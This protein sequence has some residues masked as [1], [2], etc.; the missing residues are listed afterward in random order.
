MAKVDIWALGCTLYELATGLPPNARI[1]HEHLS[2]VVREQLPKLEGTKYSPGL[3]ELVEFCF[4]RSPRKRPS[5]EMVQ[6]H[7]YISE[8]SRHY[9]TS[10][11]TR[12]LYD[13]YMWEHSGGQRASLF[14]PGGAPPPEAL[15][16][17]EQ[18][19]NF[20]TTEI[21]DQ[22]VASTQLGFQPSGLGS[23]SVRD[24]QYDQRRGPASQTLEA[25]PRIPLNPLERLF[26]P[27]DSYN[28]AERGQRVNFMAPSDLP[29]REQNENTSRRETLIDVGS[30]DPSTGMAT[31]PDLSTIREPRFSRFMRDSDDESEETLRFQEPS[32]DGTRRA[33]RDWTFP[34]L[35]APHSNQEGE[36]VRR[37]TQDWTFPVMSADQAST[38]AGAEAT[39]GLAGPARRR[40]P[41]LMRKR[42]R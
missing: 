37:N 22:H 19:W 13:Y 8:T 23:S 20:S 38:T 2:Y 42:S 10:S 35:Q 17:H 9:P 11:L 26:I 39:P 32:E 28:Y 24:F 41:C 31:I 12:L 40:P 21:F 16:E 36:H 27:N 29:L 6:N 30:I 18:E 14:M 4:E 33:T 34:S 25:H 1:A 3:R 5:I 15:Q 7:Y